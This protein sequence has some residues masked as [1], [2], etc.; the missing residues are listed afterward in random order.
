MIVYIILVS[1]LLLTIGV[2][3]IAT[4]RPK[5]NTEEFF[6]AGRNLKILPIFFTLVATNF[7]AFFFLGFA[8]ESYRVGY[9][10]YHMMA[11]GTGFVAVAF[12]LIG[13]KAWHLGKTR[14]Y[15]TSVEMIGSETNSPVLRNLYLLVLLVFE[16]PFLAIQPIGAGLILEQLTDGAISY[17]WGAS[18]LT[19][20]IIAYVFIGGMKGIVSMDIKNGII[21]FSLM[22]LAPLVIAHNLGGL[23]SINSFLLENKPELFSVEG[24]KQFFNP[25][26]WL[27]Y[28]L[29]WFCAIPMHPQIFS[30]FLMSRDI[31]TFRTTTFLFTLIPPLLFVLPVMVGVMGHMSHPDLVG[32][33]AD[34]I[35]PMMLV[36]H[37]PKWL[38]ALVLTGALAAFMST[39]DS[40]LLALSSIITRDLYRNH[41]KKD[42]SNKEEVRIARISII[43][44]SLISLAI[45]L[46]QPASIFL[47]ATLTFS[48]VAT[49]FPTTLAVFYWKKTHP[50]ACIVSIIAGLL[51]LFSFHFQW[52]PPGLGFGFLPVFH[53]VVISFLCIGLGSVW[54]NRMERK[55]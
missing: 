29:L 16:L 27:S 49:L 52:L 47:I 22:I 48:A 13:H 21:M 36:E 33:Q 12:Y 4:K 44:L 11:F 1:Y 20:F 35:L 25:E 54:F 32:K 50:L 19:L 3:L 34:S 30:R 15:V 40:I 45:A 14:G 10:Y 17:H 37:A 42:I 31:P 43:T 51:V 8:G 7:S 26:K 18:L 2:G 5:A 46:M 24:Q 41:I 28:L 55:F 6:L 23:Q 38:G 39:M 53:A 9:S